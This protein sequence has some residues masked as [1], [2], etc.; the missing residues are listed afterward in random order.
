MAF[1]TYSQNNFRNML[2][3]IYEMERIDLRIANK[4]NK[5]AQ[6]YRKWFLLITN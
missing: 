3:Q 4:K 2:S 6:H 1:V 5:Y